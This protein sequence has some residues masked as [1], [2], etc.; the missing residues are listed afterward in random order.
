MALVLA[1][2]A[3]TGDDGDEPQ[4]QPTRFNAVESPVQPPDDPDAPP[5]TADSDTDDDTDL[6][7]EDLED[8]I[9]PEPAEPVVLPSQTPFS[10]GALPVAPPGTLIASQTEDPAILAGSFDRIYFEQVRGTEEPLIIEIFG[11]GRVI[12]NEVEGIVDLASIGDLDA[13][14]DAVNYFG[15]QAT[16]MGPP[17]REEAYRYQLFVQQGD[18][19]KMINAQD[20]YI[21]NEVQTIF[22]TIRS[23]GDAV[24]SAQP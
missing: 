15:L 13:Q 20:G 6:T 11:D 21:P 5:P 14:L 18:L 8:Q 16:Y 12:A 24:L 4:V 23:L 17:G 1:A 22:G 7:F 9:Q 10:E 2:C 19:E 3:D